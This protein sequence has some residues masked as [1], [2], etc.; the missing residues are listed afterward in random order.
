MIALR[1]NPDSENKLLNDLQYAF[2][3]GFYNVTHTGSHYN[4]QNG[5]HFLF[6]SK[7][8]KPSPKSI[9]QRASLI[10]FILIFLQVFP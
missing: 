4:I 10:E 2:P 5:C 9:R 3:G 7:K 1:I 8:C 6:K